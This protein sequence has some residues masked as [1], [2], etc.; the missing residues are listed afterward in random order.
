M[1]E[2]GTSVCAEGG[3]K[4]SEVTRGNVE[5]TM[6]ISDEEIDHRITCTCCH[7]FYELIDE[8]GYCS[9]ADGDC[10]EGLQV[11]DDA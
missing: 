8:W 11:V 5:R 10:I 7:A 1:Q 9:I 2:D 4:A 6:V 3:L